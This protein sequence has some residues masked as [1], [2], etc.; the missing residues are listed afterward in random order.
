MHFGWTDL[1][2]FLHV[3]E[4]GSMTAGAARSHLTLAAASARIRALEEASGV[5]LLA[6]QPRGVTPTAAGTVLAGHARLVLEQVQRLEHDLVHARAAPVRPLVILANSSALARPWTLALAESQ[7]APVLVR[8]SASEVAVRS[9]RSGCADVGIVSDAVETE[10]LATHEL[11]PDPLVLVVAQDHA[12][13]GRESV[14]FAEASRLAWVSWGERSALS[15]HLLL[16]AAACGVQ[17]VPGFTYPTAGGVLQLVA[18][19]LG[20]TVLP[21]A[22]VHQHGAVEGIACVRLDDRWAQRRLLACHS[23]NGDPRRRQVAEQIS[24]HWPASSW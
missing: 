23:L 17:L 4:S 11:G 24:R 13:A 12:W 20:V 10:G 18:L 1:Q 16:R 3:C 21:E 6:R 8:E 15:T 7:H 22:V 19:G 9:L 14:R 5:L 2:I